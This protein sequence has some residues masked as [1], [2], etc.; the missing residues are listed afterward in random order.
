MLPSAR[1]F[2][3]CAANWPIV[4]IL[5]WVVCCGATGS[6]TR[7]DLASIDHCRLRE[8]VSVCWTEIAEPVRCRLGDR[9]RRPHRRVAPVM[10]AFQHL[11]HAFLRRHLRLPAEFGAYLGDVGPGAVGF[12]RALRDVHRRR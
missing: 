7:G 2:R 4:T 1:T 3:A 8:T 6:S 12:A 9:G 11:L 5:D 10:N